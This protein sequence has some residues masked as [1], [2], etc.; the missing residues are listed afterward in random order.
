MDPKPLLLS[1]AS[2]ARVPS[3]AAG[4]QH[5]ARLGNSMEGCWERLIQG[6]QSCGCCK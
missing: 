5:V 2:K 4:S 3:R 1:S 6:V